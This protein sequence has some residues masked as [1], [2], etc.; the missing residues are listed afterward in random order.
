MFMR[1]KLLNVGVALIAPVLFVSLIGILRQEASA[2]A[3]GQ[4]GG[5][6]AFLQAY[7]EAKDGKPVKPLRWMIERQ[8]RLGRLAGGR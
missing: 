6:A 8:Y 7:E 5:G 4:F 3:S 2:G 1:P